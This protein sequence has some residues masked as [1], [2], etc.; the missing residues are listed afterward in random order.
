M[1]KNSWK[2][3]LKDAQTGTDS[4]ARAPRRGALS[5]VKESI[6]AF[7]N[8]FLEMM[9]EPQPRKPEIHMD[10]VKPGFVLREFKHLLKVNTTCS[11]MLLERV[12]GV[13]NFGFSDNYF[14]ARWKQR[15]INPP[16]GSP[17]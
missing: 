17:R 16:A 12:N 6:D 1:N 15:L 2:D 8:I 11:S 3:L 9:G 10:M 5:L 13:D 7:V 4:R 14:R